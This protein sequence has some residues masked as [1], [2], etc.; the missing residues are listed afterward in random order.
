MTIQELFEEYAGAY[1][2]VDDCEYIDGIGCK[3]C[4]EDKERMG[5]IIQ[6]VEALVRKETVNELF[7]N[8]DCVFMMEAHD[9]LNS[10]GITL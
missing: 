2:Q 9:W 5:Q 10:K 1:K 6:E 3:I 8:Q 7:K 4:T